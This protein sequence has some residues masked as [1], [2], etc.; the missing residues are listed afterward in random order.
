MAQIRITRVD[1][2]ETNSKTENNAETE[3]NTKEN[4]VE[5]EVDSKQSDPIFNQITENIKYN[6][7][8][9]N[10]SSS[11]LSCAT[12]EEI[13]QIS[14]HYTNIP[15]DI[16]PRASYD[17]GQKNTD[18]IGVAYNGRMRQFILIDG[19]GITTW[20]RDA[21][22]Q[23]VS[24]ALCFAKYQ[25]RLFTHIIYVR[26]FNCYFVLTKDFS[27]KVLNRD[28]EETYSVCADLR[29]ILFMLFNPAKDELITG[30]VGGTK[31][32]TFHQVS[33]NVFNNLKPMANYRL[34]LKY[35]L[36]E[37]G[38]SWVKR[39][40]LDSELGHL[41][42]CSDTDLNVYNFEGKVLF[43]FRKAHKQTITGCR[44]SQSAKVLVTSSIDCFVKVWSMTGGLVHTFRGHA[45][46]V[47]NLM[48][49][50]DNS[51]III[52]SSLDGTIRMWSLETLEPL[53]SLV[54]SSEGI[55]WMGLTDDEK[56]YM[57]TSRHLTLWSL[58]YFYEYWSTARSKLTKMSLVGCQN[59]TTR[60]L[61]V[62][63]DNSVRLFARKSHKN[64][65]TILPPPDL[66][67]LEEISS[68]CYSREFNLAFLL[69]DK[70]E[71][72]TN[73]V[74]VYTTRTDPSCRIAVWNIRELQ[75][76]YIMKRHKIIDS[77]VNNGTSSSFYNTQ[78][79]NAV[80]RATENGSG[81]ET[82]TV[83]YCV[84]LLNSM[85][86]MLS[87]EGEACPTRQTF[88][89][90][91]MEVG[92]YTLDITI[93]TDINITIGIAIDI[94]NIAVCMNIT[95]SI[96]ITVGY[97]I[98]FGFVIDTAIDIDNILYGTAL[99]YLKYFQD[100]RIF[101]MDPVVKG[102][103][104]MEFKA[105]KDPI[106]Q[107]SHDVVHNTL[108]TM[109][110]L[111][112]LTQIFIWSLPNLYLQYEVYC[113]LDL[114]DYTRMND[115]FVTG[116]ESGCLNTY[117]LQAIIPP[118][119]GYYKLRSV[120]DYEEVVDIYKRPEHL[121]CIIC[122]DSSPSMKLL[123]SCSVEGAIKIWDEERYLLTEIML[124]DSLS[125]ALF[126]NNKADLVVGFKNH[127]F[128]IDHKHIC[129]HLKF[130]GEE[131]D[132]DH[133]SIIYEDPAVKFEGIGSD[134]DPID[135]DQY[136]I[137][138]E[139]EFSK[140]F[141]EGKPLWESSS[142]EELELSDMESEYSMA[143]TEIYYSPPETPGKLANIDL[144]VGSE[145]TQN[146]LKAQ[147]LS[148]MQQIY[149]RALEIPSDQ[150]TDDR[151]TKLMEQLRLAN[152]LRMR[153]G[154]AHNPRYKKKKKKE[155]DLLTSDGED[156]EDRKSRW[157][158]S[159]P[160]FGKSPG[161]SPTL[162]FL[163][164]TPVL[165]SDDGSDVSYEEIVGEDG[166]I[167]KQKKPKKFKPIEAAEVTATNVR[168]SKPSSRYKGDYAEGE[169]SGIGDVRLDVKTLL[170]KVAAEE[171][172]KKAD[173]SH[174]RAEIDEHVSNV[175]RK[176]KDIQKKRVTKRKRP[177]QG[178]KVQVKTEKPKIEEQHIEKEEVEPPEVPE[179]ILE[180]EHPDSE[181]VTQVTLPHMTRKSTHERKLVDGQ[182]PN[183]PQVKDGPEKTQIERNYGT[184]PKK[185]MIEFFDMKKPGVGKSPTSELESEAAGTVRDDTISNKLFISL[186][187]GQYDT[188]SNKSFI[189]LDTLHDNTISNKLFISL[190]TIQDDTIS[191]K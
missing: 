147:M 164:T 10:S 11:I 96:D 177:K 30:G 136:L 101:F 43:R 68:L 73:E 94:D 2:D 23:R 108:I 179:S 100:G 71:S 123:C 149:D 188:I 87:D 69:I 56:L 155:D 146:E 92:I 46:A 158:F 116:H 39:V 44:Y 57:C 28:F 90:L 169:S 137:P 51:S 151:E 52:T 40:E 4:K 97:Y 98:T 22:N 165:D 133:E 168:I 189:S 162:S 65:S 61:T 62:G 161:P 125:S 106:V 19:R 185:N 127:I 175:V 14:D 139:I 167:R 1:Y 76:P 145:I 74:W 117:R 70:N 63:D 110:R 31:F 82:M 131:D 143:P 24:R 130:D 140:D 58:N 49:H 77:N 27:L 79:V 88:L 105:S 153:Q 187:A 118:D 91:G 121:E 81:N 78:E 48:I 166:I 181:P 114:V 45:R 35:E 122:L 128:Y 17:H 99:C 42:C 111:K 148:T 152:M 55:L 15:Y 26:K 60:I 109:S 102:Q 141:L 135:L 89:L 170:K 36:P 163:S 54:V 138:Y 172:A 3:E 103:K 38:G 182:I 132:F 20:K 159:F 115:L 113:P 72:K 190:D 157:Q 32:W 34:T 84:C 64:L 50:P 144:I 67:P 154:F 47:T 180:E 134:P 83:C 156:E 37:V 191:N 18:I 85:L 9:R 21:V 66:S 178:Q 7:E 95:I 183:L 53:Y 107:M 29:C 112:Y 120:P 12:E 119:N 142:E 13:L 126:L 80:F 41:Y 174:V 59:K 104:Y 6:L 176:Q 93:D 16:Q 173:H 25:Y 86:V 160:K 186:D 184:V 8:K 124:D 150:E 5:D 33:E 171:A 129:P 75:I